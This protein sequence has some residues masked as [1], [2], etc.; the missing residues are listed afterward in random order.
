MDLRSG[1]LLLVLR[2]LPQPLRLDRQHALVS[3]LPKHLSENAKLQLLLGSVIG[4]RFRF[5][6]GYLAGLDQQQIRRA[7]IQSR[8]LVSIYDLRQLGMQLFER[9]VD[10]SVHRGAIY[11]RTVSAAP[12][13]SVHHIQGQMYSYDLIRRVSH[14][15]FV[16][17]F[18]RR[19][20]TY[21]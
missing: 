6:G 1:H 14:Y 7:G 2:A 5:L 9:L 15:A 8:R 17:V 4:G 18:H 16:H 20:Y 19:N 13:Q 10:R 3:G 21:V 11:R 12:A